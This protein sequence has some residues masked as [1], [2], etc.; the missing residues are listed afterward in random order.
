[1]AW[2]NDKI[3]LSERENDRGWGMGRGKG[4]RED[5]E[6][7]REDLSLWPAVAP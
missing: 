2:P 7:G 1:M 3:C 5:R 4:E 6:V